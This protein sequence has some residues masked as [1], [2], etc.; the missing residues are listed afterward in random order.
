M[1]GAYFKFLV[2]FF[3]IVMTFELIVNYEAHIHPLWS[4]PRTIPDPID[5]LLQLDV[6][7]TTAGCHTPLDAA[8]MVQVPAADLDLTDGPSPD[9][10]DHFN[11]YHEILFP[12]SAQEVDNGALR[13]I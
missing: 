11:A 8:A 6:T 2:K 9:E 1:A 12:D 4:A 13:P 5:P 7:C 3:S 10:A